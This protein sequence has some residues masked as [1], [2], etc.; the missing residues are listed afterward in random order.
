MFRNLPDIT[1]A[2]AE[3]G[4]VGTSASGSCT[5]VSLS[6]LGPLTSLLSG[7][8]PRSHGCSHTLLECP[9]AQQA[10]GGCG[11][12][13]RRRARRRKAGVRGL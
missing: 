7:P 12:S 6:A 13:S 3:R 11:N 9:L 5:G 10:L 2:V 4:A 8:G 1:L